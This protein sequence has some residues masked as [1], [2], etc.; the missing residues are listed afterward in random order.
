[1]QRY[2]IHFQKKL[3]DV[4]DKVAY[5]QTAN[6]VTLAMAKIEVTFVKDGIERTKLLTVAAT[7]GPDGHELSKYFSLYL[8]KDALYLDTKMTPGQLVDG[9]AAETGHA[10]ESIINWFYEAKD[11]LFNQDEKVELT[12]KVFTKNGTEI[13]TKKHVL[14]PGEVTSIR[15]KELAASRAICNRV[16]TQKVVDLDAEMFK[17][18]N[19]I[20]STQAQDRAAEIRKME[21]AAK[22]ASQDAA[23]AEKKAGGRP[24]F[25]QK[26]INGLKAVHTPTPFERL[27]RKV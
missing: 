3:L 16:C 25:V 11:K 7:S 13:C 6:S 1:M 24:R 26:G 8:P 17:E 12:R 27:V 22:K 9:L 20:D 5:R 4:V 14:Y 21:E 10:E 23:A 19:K 2:R 18:L 15:V